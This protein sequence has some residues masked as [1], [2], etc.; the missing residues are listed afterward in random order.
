MT[1]TFT[2][3]LG[4]ALCMLLAVVVLVNFDAFSRNLFLIGEA[5]ERSSGSSFCKATSF[6]VTIILAVASTCFIF[7]HICN[8]FRM[9]L[10][11][12]PAAA[13]AGDENYVPGV[14]EYARIASLA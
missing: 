6:L 7:F 10:S 8:G 11:E 4:F 12:C 5:R 14:E 13:V 3:A 2:L 9:G 1:L